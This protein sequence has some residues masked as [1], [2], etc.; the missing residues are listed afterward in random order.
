MVTEVVSMLLSLADQFTL[1]ALIRNQPDNGDQCEDPPCYGGMDVGKWC[2]NNVQCKAQVALSIPTDRFT[3]HGA[4][5]LTSN[6]GLLKYGIGHG[7]HEENGS[8]KGHG[9]RRELVFAHP[10][11]GERDQ[12]QPEQQVQVGPKDT[13]VHVLGGVKEVMVIVPIDPYVNEAEQVTEEH[14]PKR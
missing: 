4:L 12:T 3:E 11:R 8:I 6:N 10:A 1:D 9:G 2:G 5:S 13:S 14:R 7:R